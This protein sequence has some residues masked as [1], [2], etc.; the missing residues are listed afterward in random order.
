LTNKLSRLYLIS[1]AELHVATFSPAD[2]SVFALLI[3]AAVMSPAVGA[4]L[5]KLPLRT[6]ADRRDAVIAAAVA[7]ANENDQ[8]K[9]VPLR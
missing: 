5:V 2:T 6:K 7:F 4:A 9:V 1:R 3:R 8:R